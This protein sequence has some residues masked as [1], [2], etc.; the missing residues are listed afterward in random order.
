[1]SELVLEQYI[2]QLI[3]SHQTK[4]VNIAW[5]G[6]EPTLMGLGFYRRTIDLVEKY[7]NR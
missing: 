6:G 5:Q 3:E 1:M 7:R 2:R 4:S